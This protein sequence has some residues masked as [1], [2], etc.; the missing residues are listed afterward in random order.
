MFSTER[1]R[2]NL[3]RELG[4]TWAGDFEDEPPE[5]LQ[6]IIDTTPAW[7]PVVLSLRHLERGGG[8]SSTP[9]VKKEVIMIFCSS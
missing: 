9:F 1:K 8:W 4:A 5:K 3:S 7:K 2:A 6:L